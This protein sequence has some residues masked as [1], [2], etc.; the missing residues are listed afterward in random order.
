VRL[1]SVPASRFVEV[2]EEIDV[3]RSRRNPAPMHQPGLEPGSS[4][5]KPDP[6]TD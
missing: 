6:L 2:V 4:A 5:Y 1:G 3:H